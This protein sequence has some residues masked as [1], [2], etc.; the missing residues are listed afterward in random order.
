MDI[1]VIIE[2]LLISIGATSAMTW[3]SY[4]M[5][6]SFRELYKEP[7]L[8]SFALERTHISH[9]ERYQETWGWLMHYVIGFLFVM[10]YHIIWAE[11][12]LPLTLLSTLILGVTSGAI[13]IFSWI[14]IFKITR[15]RAPIDFNGCYIQLFFAHIFFALIVA[16]FTFISE[17]LSIVA[18]NYVIL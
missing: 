12:I 18:K 13:G 3:F 8:L 15:Y 9:S 2:L 4:A 17:I 5:S 7:V 10:G 14:F 11:N 16:S 1:Y 6:G